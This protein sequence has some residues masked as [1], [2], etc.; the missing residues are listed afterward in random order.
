MRAAELV[1]L[2]DRRRLALSLEE[3]SPPG[4]GVELDRLVE[5]LM[6]PGPIAPGGVAKALLMIT[7]CD[8]PLWGVGGAARLAEVAGEALRATD[9]LPTGVASRNLDVQPA[10]PHAGLTAARRSSDPWI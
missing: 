3:L 6:A 7:E 4:S 2:E 5:R 8:G 10:K 9:S 1:D